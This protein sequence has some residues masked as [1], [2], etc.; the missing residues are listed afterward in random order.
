MSLRALSPVDGVLFGARWDPEEECISREW[1][2]GDNMESTLILRTFGAGWARPATL[3]SGMLYRTSPFAL[4][5]RRLAPS[6]CGEGGGWQRVT[7]RMQ[8]VLSFSVD[9][10]LDTYH[11]HTPIHLMPCQGD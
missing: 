9:G 6:I 5:R 2:A 4:A 3:S 8:N 1:K 11:V 10:A 7:G